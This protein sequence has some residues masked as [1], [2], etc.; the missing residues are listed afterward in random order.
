M[1]LN[2]TVLPYSINLRNI[3]AAINR[4]IIFSNLQNIWLCLSY[5]NHDA[6]Q[7]PEAH[8]LAGTLNRNPVILTHYLQ[9]G[10][11]LKRESEKKNCEQIL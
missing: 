2:I 9:R 5:P 10:C 8:S 7:T 11:I 3:S 4:E 1:N 6:G